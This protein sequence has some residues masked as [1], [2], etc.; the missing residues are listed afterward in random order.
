M[1][2]K[3]YLSQLQKLDVVIEQKLQELDELKKITVDLKGIDYTKEKVKSSA[4]HCADFENTIIKIMDLESK[5][6]AEIDKFVDKKHTIINQIQAL[7]DTKYVQVLHKRYVEYK[8][9]EQI[10]CEMGYTYDYVRKVH[11][12]ALID[13]EKK[14]CKIIKK[15]QKGT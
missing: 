6:N 12:R 11:S 1:R 8:G 2:A 3:Q 7:N 4:T 9:F 5:I 15:A 10:A 13:F 14:I